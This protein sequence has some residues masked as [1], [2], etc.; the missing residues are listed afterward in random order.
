M[1]GTRNQL[2]LLRAYSRMSEA[3]FASAMGIPLKKLQDLESGG[4]ALHE[5]HLQAA[6]MALVQL[7]TMFPD[8]GYLPMPI[9]EFIQATAQQHDRIFTRV[10]RRHWPER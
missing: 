6:R 3:D 1:R 7:A 9:D 10:R 5:V 2:G 4:S 8:R